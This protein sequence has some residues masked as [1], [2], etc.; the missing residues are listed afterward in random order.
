[1]ITETVLDSYRYGLGGTW[2]FVLFLK[3]IPN[4]TVNFQNKATHY[5]ISDICRVRSDENAAIMD[6]PLRSCSGTHV[7]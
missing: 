1:M 4:V 3:D 5:L 6:V 2:F 7:N